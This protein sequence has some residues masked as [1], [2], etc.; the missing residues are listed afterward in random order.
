MPIVKDIVSKCLDE[1][2]NDVQEKG[3]PK[4]KMV[5]LSSDSDEEDDKNAPTS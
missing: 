4:F 5:T 3:Q 2:N 1:S